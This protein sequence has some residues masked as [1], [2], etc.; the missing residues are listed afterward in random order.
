MRM[1]DI[2]THDEHTASSRLN[3]GHEAVFKR[4]VA[5]DLDDRFAARVNE[6]DKGADGVDA[7]QDEENEED[8]LGEPGG[9]EH[10]E[11]SFSFSDEALSGKQQFTRKTGAWAE[12]AHVLDRGVHGPSLYYRRVGRFHSQ[13]AARARKNLVL[14]KGKI[15][16]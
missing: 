1:R 9:D 12:T 2:K 6:E 11:T 16:A 5:Q 4:A 10:P 8:L 15:C 7:A 14:C 3:S 13:T